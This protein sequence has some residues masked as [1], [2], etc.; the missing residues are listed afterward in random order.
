MNYTVPPGSGGGSGAPGLT[1]V[2]VSVSSVILSAAQ[3]TGNTLFVSTVST[4][5]A[6]WTLPAASTVTP[7]VYEFVFEGTTFPVDNKVTVNAHAGDVFRNPPQEGQG[8]T[9]TTIIILEGHSITVHCDGAYW[10]CI[11]A[12]IPSVTT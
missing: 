8:S 3:F 11:G 2:L 9:A 10:W 6:S 12:Y 7:G 5:D 1:I 4:G